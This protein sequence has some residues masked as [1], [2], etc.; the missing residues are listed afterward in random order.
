MRV[1]FVSLPGIGHAFPMVPLAWAL[2]SAGH[3]VLIATAGPAV[4]VENAGLPVVD[5]APG[6]DRKQIMARVQQQRP[7]LAERMRTLNAEK[8]TDLREAAEFLAMLSGFLVDGTSAAAETWQPDLIV[9]SQLQGAGL[10]VASKLGIPLVEHGFGLAR[11]SGMAELHRQC[12]SEAFDRHGVTDLPQ[13]TAVVDVAPPSM[14][15]GSAKGWP[16][17]YVPYNGG[18]VLPEWLRE[19]EERPRVAVTLGTVVPQHAGLGAV[20]Q[21]LAAADG[22]DAEFVLALGDADTSTLDALPPNVRVSGWIPLGELLRSCS[23]VV[24][25]GGAGTTL[26]A[27]DAGVPQLV[28]PSGA[29]RYINATAVRDRGVGVISEDQSVDTDALRRL[30]RD[31]ALREAAVEV[32]S[33]IRAMPAPAS[34]LPRLNDL[35]AKQ[36]TV[37]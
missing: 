33:E 18:G 3:E 19:R 21:V 6:F 14:I 8:L 17:R 32:Q 36:A 13:R 34:L 22:L 35:A 16:M 2:R 23:A 37:D 5:V 4:A 7:D 31:P 24:H 30:L 12:M 15:D 11:S 10:V 27:L 1:L 28:L 26:T 25:H 20:P 29:D 9:Q